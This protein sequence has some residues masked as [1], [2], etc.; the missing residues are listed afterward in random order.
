MVVPTCMLYLT[1]WNGQPVL[2]QLSRMSE[3]KT[4]L[5]HVG[6]V[7]RHVYRPDCGVW[8]IECLN[9]NNRRTVYWG[10]T[11]DITEETGFPI[12]PGARVKIGNF[13]AY[14]SYPNNVFMVSPGEGLCA[15][16]L[17]ENHQTVSR[18]SN[19]PPRNPHPNV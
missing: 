17:N 12:A 13:P 10:H 18:N 4:I 8:N 6:T 7:A 3:V 5:K 1:F 15:V 19:S 11:P 2:I 14:V 16:H 9:L